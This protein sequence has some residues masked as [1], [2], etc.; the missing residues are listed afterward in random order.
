VL[1]LIV[2]V[3]FNSCCSFCKPKV[4]AKVE[5]RYPDFSDCIKLSEK[6]FVYPALPKISRKFF[7]LGD[8]QVLLDNLALR[9]KEI[10]SLRDVNY[11]FITNLQKFVATFDNKEKKE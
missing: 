3:S 11:C 2:A 6:K 1:T 5:Y 10:E 4:I 7:S 9:D 8:I